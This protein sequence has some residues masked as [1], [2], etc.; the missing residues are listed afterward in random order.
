MTPSIRMTL[1]AAILAASPLALAAAAPA[2]TDEA[3]SLAGARLE[4]APPC[5][6]QALPAGAQVASSTDEAR[7]VMAGAQ[8]LEQV[9]QRRDLPASATPSSTDEERALT[10]AWLAGTAPGPAACVASLAG[11]TGNG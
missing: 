1:A 8:P 9:G 6:D 3:R 10:A 4:A 11:S 2:S 5:P 7:A